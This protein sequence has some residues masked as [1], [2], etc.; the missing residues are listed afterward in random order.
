[1]VQ[2]QGLYVGR[3][4]SSISDAVCELIRQS[5]FI[6][7]EHQEHPTS[8][9]H[10]RISGFDSDIDAI[11]V[12]GLGSSSAKVMISN[13]TS[14]Q[15]TTFDL[16]APSG[17]SLLGNCGEW[18]VEAFGTIGPLAQFSPIIFTDCQGYTAG[19]VSVQAGSGTELR[20]VD[21]QN[22]MVAAGIIDGP[23]QVTVVRT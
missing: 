18:I 8:H 22:V 21:A 14:K 16:L 6:G 5:G 1:M 2:Q 15:T 9:F 11:Q 17:N 13:Q 10:I 20:L 23:T 7:K 3:G 19:G 12:L 4:S